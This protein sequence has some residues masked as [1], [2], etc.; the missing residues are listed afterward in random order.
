MFY[1]TPLAQLKPDFMKSSK[2]D[3]FRKFMQ[4]DQFIMP[5]TSKN[6][7][8]HIASGTFVRACVRLSVMLCDV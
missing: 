4:M 6:L 2:K 1:K 8:V 7:E 3:R 5:P